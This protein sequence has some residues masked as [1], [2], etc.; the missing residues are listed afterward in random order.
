M[1]TFMK[2]A[3]LVVGLAVA[4]GAVD[5]DDRSDHF[6]GLLARDLQTAVANFSEYNRLFEQELSGEL[7][8]ANLAKIH[9]LTY[10][11]EVALE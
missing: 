3:V 11:L 4:G 1:Y 2:S 6:K 8:N 5:D 9:Q 10:T 7:S